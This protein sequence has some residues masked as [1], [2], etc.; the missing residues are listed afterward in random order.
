MQAQCDKEIYKNIILYRGTS[1]YLKLLNVS[2]F[3]VIFSLKN[4]KMYTTVIVCQ[5]N[6][7]I[8]FNDQ[9]A[10]DGKSVYKHLLACGAREE[11]SDERN[12]DILSNTLCGKVH[13]LTLEALWI[14]D[15]KPSINAK[16]EY[17]RRELII[18][19]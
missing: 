12:L 19:F 2:T 15:I 10:T 7:I 6:E 13:I 9:R 3:F 16:H 5:I 14:G 17:R 1:L 18:T 11:L 4:K 8:S